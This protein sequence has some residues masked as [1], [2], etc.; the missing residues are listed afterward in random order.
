MKIHS[1][2]KE[3]NK[4][5]K[6]F[7]NSTL[8]HIDKAIYNQCVDDERS[9]KHKEFKKQKKIVQTLNAEIQTKQIYF[10]K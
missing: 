1:C 5:L 6:H 3:P 2:M 8:P 4:R 9:S 7:Y 10:F